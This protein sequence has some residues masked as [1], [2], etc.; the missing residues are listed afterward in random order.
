MRLRRYLLGIIIAVCLTLI[1]YLSFDRI[2]LFAISKIY[3]LDISYK[4]LTKDPGSGYAFKDFRIMNKKMGIGFIC[5]RATIKP[6]WGKNILR[7]VFLD[8]RLKDVHFLKDRA[9]KNKTTYDTLSQLVAMPFEGR[10]MYKDV[11]G[12]V[13]L[14]SN[15]MTVK[16]FQ[17]KGGSMRL[18]VS[19]DLYYDNTADVDITIFFHKDTLKEIPPELC[20][21]IL[22]DEQDDWKSFSVKLKG[23]MNSPALQ[24]SGKLFR[25]NI[26]TAVMNE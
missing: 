14:F 3:S 19:G 12:K 22:Q 6:S 5:G 13:E 1:I 9:D 24:I 10:W 17:A 7:S 8:F 2:A 15:G 16:S 4:G 23:D 11:S 20:S 25:L 26:G 18:T 21:V